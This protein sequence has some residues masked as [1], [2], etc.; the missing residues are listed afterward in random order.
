LNPVLRVAGIGHHGAAAA[1]AWD[2]IL[3]WFDR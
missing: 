2:R 3:R 1:D